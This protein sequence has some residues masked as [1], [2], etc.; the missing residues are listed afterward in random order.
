[1]DD[2]ERFTEMFRAFHAPVTAYA[3]RRVPLE[4]AQDVVAATFLAAWRHRDTLP[5]DP[6]P[7]LYRAAALEVSAQIRTDRRRLRLWERISQARSDPS[8]SDHADQVAMAAHWKAAFAALSEGDRE[9]LRLTAWEQLGPKQASVIM[10]CSPV[11]F[12]VRLHRARR[13]LEALVDGDQSRLREPTKSGSPER[14]LL[15]N[16]NSDC[17]PTIETAPPRCS[18][19]PQQE[20]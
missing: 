16:S 13:R 14:P 15:L 3:R 9:V 19:P 20:V 11:A 2:N 18:V 5:G 12:K 1:V 10:G 4:T 6:L 7:W 8:E 17:P